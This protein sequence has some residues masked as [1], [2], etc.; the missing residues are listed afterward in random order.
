[1]ASSTARAIDGAALDRWR[2]R[3]ARAAD[4]PWLHRE[5]ARRMAERLPVVR[6]R[7]EVVIDW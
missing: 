6:L 4:P 1:M 2:Q 5:V 7:P 3:T